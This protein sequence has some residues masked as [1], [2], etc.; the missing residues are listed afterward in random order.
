MLFRAQKNQ[1]KKC[2]LTCY[3]DIVFGIEILFLMG[4]DERRVVVDKD[5]GNG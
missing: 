2:L 4:P 3:D 5:D 1:R